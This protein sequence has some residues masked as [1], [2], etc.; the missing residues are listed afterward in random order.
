M[1]EGV[2]RWKW[3]TRRG[4][5]YESVLGPTHFLKSVFLCLD[6]WSTEVFTV[7]FLSAWK[8]VLD[9]NFTSSYGSVSIELNPLQ[10][11]L[12]CLRFNK[13]YIS[14]WENIYK[15]GKWVTDELGERIMYWI[16]IS[17]LLFFFFSPNNELLLL[18][19][20]AYYEKWVL[21]VRQ[22]RLH[23]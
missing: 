16:T 21:V 1:T 12:K 23:A 2:F 8:S 13:R 6:H 15:L 11:C 19:L 5:L 20:L 9:D 7:F 3:I 10:M 14:V 18:L 22:N 4:S 17:L